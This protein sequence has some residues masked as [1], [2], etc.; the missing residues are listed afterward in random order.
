MVQPKY[1]FMC[2][3]R[4]NQV[5]TILKKMLVTL[6]IKLSWIRACFCTDRATD[7][8]VACDYHPHN[9]WLLSD[10]QIRRVILMER[11]WQRMK[12]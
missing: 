4:C 9:V 3:I 8:I 7:S 10:N 2:V 1:G 11:S 6:V 12:S 5:R